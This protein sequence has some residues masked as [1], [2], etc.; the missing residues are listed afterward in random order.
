M[1]SQI[2]RRSAV[3]LFAGL[4][5]AASLSSADVLAQLGLNAT[6]AKEQ[7]MSGLGSGF[8]NY[9][10]AAPAFKKAPAALRV[11]LAE[12]AIAWA[13]THTAS[14]EFKTAYATLRENRKPHAPEF[15]GT[16]EEEYA[17]HR[18]QQ[19][20][21]QAK[22][23]EDMKKAMAS[24]TPEMRKQMEAAMEQSAAVMKQMDTPEMHKMMLDGIRM[25]REEKT[26][27]YQDDMTK[28]QAEYP[29]SPDPVIA[30]RLKA[31]LDTSATVDFEAKLESK[32]G[33]M[34]FVNPEYEN[35]PSEWKLCYRAGQETVAAA[36]SAAQAW[37]KD[38]GR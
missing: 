1:H 3:C 23:V 33:K 5:T 31:F 12:G 27:R 6:A 16:P 29:E 9:S 30:K 17:R 13:R 18:E 34:R 19:A 25:Q 15:K 2:M 11:Q 7:L 22:G 24:M 21:D 4:V 36:R 14:P 26:R 8:I 37:M 35:K 38:L 32:Y 10:L 28:W 20:K